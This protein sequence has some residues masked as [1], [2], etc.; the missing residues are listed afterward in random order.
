MLGKVLRALFFQPWKVVGAGAPD[1]WEIRVSEDGSKIAVWEPGNE[2]WFVIDT[3]Q[4]K[5]TWVK[6]SKMDRMGWEPFLPL[7]EEF[8]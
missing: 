5:G 4:V 8:K 7:R 1:E 6:S 3:A 2:P